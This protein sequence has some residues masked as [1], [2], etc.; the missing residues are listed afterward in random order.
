MKNQ[1]PKAGEADFQQVDVAV[2]G[3]GPAG[4]GAAVAAACA[5][6]HTTLIER[7]P[8]LGGMGTA[9]L[10]NNFCPAHH[11]GERFIIGGLFGEL[12][13]R[14]IDRKA[15]YAFTASANTKPRMEPYDPGMFTEEARA[16]CL[17]SGVDLRFQT[18]IV[19]CEFHL[20]DAAELVLDDGVRLK[21]RTVVDATG[22]ATLAAGAG[23]PCT[24]GQ[25]NTGAVMPLTY[26]YLMG[27]IDLDAA[28]RAF[29]N[30]VHHDT[31]LNERY[32]YFSG[33]HQVVDG[34][35]K[36]ARHRGELTIPRDHISAIVS[37]PGRPQYASVNFGRV[38]IEDP[39]DPKQLEAAEAEGRRQVDEGIR[40]FRKYLPGFAD[41]E[42]LELA[43]QIGVRQSRQI[44][45]LYTLTGE[46]VL[47]ARQFDDCIAQCCYPIDIH[48]PGKDTTIM[49][50]LPPGQH[51]DIP[52][53]CLVPSDGPGNLIV[54]GR[55]I[56]ATAEAMSSFRVSPSALAIG[57]AA[58][59]TAAFA[60]R[61]RCAIRDVR[62]ADVRRTLLATGGILE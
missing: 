20:D 26:C 8:V 39:T 45:G 49:K 35:V 40:F 5:G 31:N 54:A 58:G 22:D 24:F 18:R 50:R 32:F 60:A 37:V 29:P 9:A 16:M 46:D 4:I 6:Q 33:W 11:D 53:R 14:L 47:A 30:A 10:V 3:G 25:P 2:C 42:L 51:F 36:A 59:V 28:A 41:V 15:V 13:Q 27:P 62:F 44:A 12:R 55:S 7:H 38:N 1:D 19:S 48:E 52:W 23:V 56:S 34:W 21:A 43:P 17:A 61:D 57:E